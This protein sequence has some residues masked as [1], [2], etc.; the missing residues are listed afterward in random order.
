MADEEITIRVT[1]EVDDEAVTSLQEALEEI[2]ELANIEI[3]VSADSS[4]LDDVQDKIDDI[5]GFIIGGD[6][7]VDSSSVDELNDKL[8]ESVDK[9]SDLGATVSGLAATLAI[10]EMANTADNVNNSKTCQFFR[11]AV[12]AK[13]KYRN[14]YQNSE[15]CHYQKRLFY[16]RPVYKNPG[17]GNQ[18]RRSNYIKKHRHSLPV[19]ILLFKKF[20]ALFIHHF[21]RVIQRHHMPC[22]R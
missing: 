19:S 17:S 10:D 22:F 1:T 3:S 11:L 14:F 21:P 2:A 18:R 12:T 5:D 13:I 20:Q 16:F 8:D 4:E 15:Q 9:S 6:V 7:E